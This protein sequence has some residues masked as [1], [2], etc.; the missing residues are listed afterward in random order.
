M[1]I[2]AFD[3]ERL[4]AE[5]KLWDAEIAHLEE[6]VERV[7]PDVQ[8]ALQSEAHDMLQAMLE[9]ELA[10]LRQLRDEAEQELK[11]MELA[12]DAEWKIQGE[13]AER[14]LA[15]LGAAFEQSRTHFGE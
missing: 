3:L 2:K 9:T 15:R 12:G 7:E 13:R 4:S 6:T 5:L 8:T 1:N 14:A 11:R 10:K